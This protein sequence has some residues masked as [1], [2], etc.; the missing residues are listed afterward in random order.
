MGQFRRFWYLT[1]REKLFFFEAGIL[2]LASNVSVKT[3]A[4]RHINSYLH[5]WNDRSRIVCSD[6][7]KNI[8]LIDLSLSR[9]ANVLPWNSLCLSRSI[10]KLIMLRRRG[11]P[12][13]LFA[14]V[15]SLEDS[16]L[17]AHAWV[18][19]GDDVMDKDRAEDAEFTVLVRIGR[20]AFADSSRNS[21]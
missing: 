16:S 10:A 11:I 3:V 2:L 14:G 6:D 18:R 12:A 1:R 17:S 8:E 7:M 21:V 15:K 9:A 19:S 4:F 20:G 13:I 5:H